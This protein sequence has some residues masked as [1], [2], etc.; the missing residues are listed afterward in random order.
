M[1]R[2]SCYWG[3]DLLVKLVPSAL[4]SEPVDVALKD[5]LLI[6]A[7]GGGEYTRSLHHTSL[8]VSR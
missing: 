4:T 2:L 5:F 6:V 1:R 7:A 8:L 3:C